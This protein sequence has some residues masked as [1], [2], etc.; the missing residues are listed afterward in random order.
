MKTKRNNVQILLGLMILSVLGLSQVTSAQSP[1]ASQKPTEPTN[2]VNT[3]TKMLYHNGPIMAGA[4][5]VYFIWYGCW[6]DTCIGGDTNTQ[7]ILTDFASS[8]GGSPYLQMNAMYPGSF[9][10]FAPSGALFY[11][12]AV[13][14]RYSHGLELTASDIQGIVDDQLVNGGLPQD[15]VGIYV[16]VASADVSSNATGF[17]IPGAQPHHGLAAS[18]GVSS[19]KYAFLGNPRRCPSVAAPQFV[20]GT[21]L[22]PTPNGSFAADAMATTL[23]H[24]VNVVTTN[25]HGSAWYDRYGLENADKCLGQY[26]PTYTTANGAR[27]NIR[28]GQRDYLI[29]QNWVNDRRG[30][31]AMNSS[32]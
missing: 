30:H 2:N 6:D 24:L 22:L 32:L 23:A 8:I 28:F 10:G 9:G 7:M 14:D 26:G 29:Q 13:Y 19:N 20:S 25:P 31:C 16:V 21:T 12:G 27:A 11:A 5:D 4:A 15:P 1:Q 17:C 3:N 18:L